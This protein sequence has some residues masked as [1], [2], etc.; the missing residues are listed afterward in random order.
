MLKE[1]TAELIIAKNFK[2]LN[3]VHILRTSIVH[4]PLFH[5]I[6]YRQCGVDGRRTETAKVR[7]ARFLK[8]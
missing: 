1:E 8:V 6:V 3:I 4:I 2:S 5:V 7:T